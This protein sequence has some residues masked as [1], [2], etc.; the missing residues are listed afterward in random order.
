MP[1]NIGRRSGRGGQ[2]FIANPTDF[3][4]GNNVPT[5]RRHDDHR[6]GCVLRLAL[7]CRLSFQADL[8]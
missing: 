1:W 3:A 7:C 6:P 8:A 5:R 2:A 4:A